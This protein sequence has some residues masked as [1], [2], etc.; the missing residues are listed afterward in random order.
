MG[1]LGSRY[2]WL[3]WPG[4]SMAKASVTIA[5]ARTLVPRPAKTIRKFFFNAVVLLSMLLS[6]EMQFPVARDSC[7]GL[8][9]GERGWSFLFVRHSPNVIGQLGRPSADGGFGVCVS[10]AFYVFR[11]VLR[12][13]QKPRQ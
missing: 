10:G 8:Q 6:V 1:S 5:P 13:R 7:G 12:N 4:I 9:I 11:E 3:T 2:A